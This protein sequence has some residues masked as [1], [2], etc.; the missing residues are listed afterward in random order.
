MN[1]E[2]KLIIRRLLECGLPFELVIGIEWIEHYWWLG[3]LLLRSFIVV[4]LNKIRM[5]GAT[6]SWFVIGHCFVVECWL[7]IALNSGVDMS[8][9]YEL[10]LWTW[11]GDLLRCQ[12]IS[13]ALSS[14][15]LIIHQLGVDQLFTYSL[16]FLEALAVLLIWA[17]LIGLLLVKFAVELISPKRYQTLW[18]L[19]IWLS[20]QLGSTLMS[21]RN[22]CVKLLYLLLRCQRTTLSWILLDVLI[23]LK[24]SFILFLDAQLEHDEL[25]LLPLLLVKLRR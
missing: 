11:V 16:K 21:K 9:G 1:L 22:S 25:L 24:N 23:C 4:Y 18:L 19:L 2:W 6:Q 3:L 20:Y 13:L 15:I 10:R 14:S 8:L 17:R 12:E 5:L 7:L